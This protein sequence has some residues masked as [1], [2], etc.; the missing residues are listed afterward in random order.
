MKTLS[1]LGVL[2]GV[3]LFAPA[4]KAI[5]TTVLWVAKEPFHRGANHRDDQHFR[6]KR[7]LNL[8]PMARIGRLHCVEMCGNQCQRI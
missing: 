7:W 3:S 2:A 6:E 8:G 4:P 1:A 5:M